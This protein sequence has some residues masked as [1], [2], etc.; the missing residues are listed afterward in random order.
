M[1]RRFTLVLTLIFLTGCGIHRTSRDGI[2]SQELPLTVDDLS[3]I[4]A[5]QKNHE[6]VMWEYRVYESPKLEQ[7]CNAIAASIAEVTTRPH[8]PY[9]VVLLDS[10]EVNMFGGPGGYIY[11]TR[12]MFD[13]IE[14]EG[15]LAGAIA[16]EITH[17]A[18]YDYSNIPQ[19]GNMRKAYNVMLQG[20]EIAKSSIGT[21]GTVAN[22]GLKGV[23]RA[24]PAIAHRFGHDQEV[25]TDEKALEALVK[26][27]YDPR[28]YLKFIEKLTKV[29][30]DDIGRFALFMNAHPPF[31]DRRT[32]LNNRIGNMHLQNGKIDF[33][34]EMMLAE[35]RQTAINNP[36]TILFQPGYESQA[37]PM[38]FHSDPE[39]KD[40]SASYKDKRWAWF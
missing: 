6:R 26:A 19:V 23:G 5:G 10:D 35:V 33:K 24:A 7:Y 4:Q 39:K 21:Y 11:V 32:V 8:L 31:A 15:E 3:E 37:A 12:G 40:S 29:E 9:K 25:E 30:M 13:F 27:G 2:I 20:S 22:Y 16:H 1:F 17:V 38:E 36:N 18:N 14:S 28:G 34:Q